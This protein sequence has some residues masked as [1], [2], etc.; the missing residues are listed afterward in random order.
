MF[1]WRQKMLMWNAGTASKQSEFGRG[2][3]DCRAIGL[4]VSVGLLESV[5]LGQVIQHLVHDWESTHVHLETHCVVDLRNQKAVGGGDVISDAK[6]SVR[7]LEHFFDGGQS[8][9]N[10]VMGPLGSLIVV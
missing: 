6:L 7:I 1:S 3:F 8:F 2:I 10:E 9:G 5:Q 4:G